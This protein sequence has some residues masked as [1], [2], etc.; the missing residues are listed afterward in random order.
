MTSLQVNDCI[1]AVRCVGC[2]YD[3]RRLPMHGKCAECGRE[4]WKSFDGARLNHADQSWLARLVWGQRLLFC[5]LIIL[6]LI[7]LV[8][9]GGFVVL[10]ILYTNS[11]PPN[12]LNIVWLGWMLLL[13]AGLAAMSAAAVMLAGR[14]PRESEQELQC[15]VRRLLARWGFASCTVVLVMIEF[16]LLSGLVPGSMRIVLT[17]A[18]VPIWLLSGSFLLM[19]LASLARRLPREKVAEQLGDLLEGH[20]RIIKFAAWS[21]ISLEFVILLLMFVSGTVPSLLVATLLI[22]FTAAAIPGVMLLVG[23][24]AALSQLQRELKYCL[25]QTRSPNNVNPPAAL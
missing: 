22:A 4:I 18:L 3:V 13:N 1:A 15:D 9:L 20:A 5:S 6:A 24:F 19:H 7:V 21:V 8:A 25:Q 16:R 10:S 23:A 17:C 12:S 2:G 11:P 14:E